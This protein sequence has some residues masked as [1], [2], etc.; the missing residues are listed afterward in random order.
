MIAI[1]CEHHTPNRS[2]YHADP[3]APKSE[4]FSGTGTIPKQER[5]LS[6]SGKLLKSGEVS[7]A[8]TFSTGLIGIIPIFLHGI[9]NPHDMNIL[10]FLLCVYLYAR[11]VCQIYAY[12]SP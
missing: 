5:L 9:G 12:V 6:Q 2:A 11:R 10:C 4:E 7:N 3:S 8:F 1:L